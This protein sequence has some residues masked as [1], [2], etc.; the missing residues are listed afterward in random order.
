M[1]KRSFET[2][3]RESSLNYFRNSGVGISTTSEQREGSDPLHVGNLEHCPPTQSNYI[4]FCHLAQEINLNEDQ[5]MPLMDSPWGARKNSR[6]PRYEEGL[7]TPR[8]MFRQPIQ[9]AAGATPTPCEPMTVEVVWLPWKHTKTELSKTTISPYQ[10]ASSHLRSV[11]IVITRNPSVQATNA[12]IS[13]R[14]QSFGGVK[15]G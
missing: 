9:V 1:W 7:P 4:F 3:S 12:R 8:S 5:I 15:P 2:L 14:H 6:Q 10:V 11:S 13:R